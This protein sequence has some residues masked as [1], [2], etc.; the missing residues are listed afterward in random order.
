[1]SRE[2]RLRKDL[3]DVKKMKELNPSLFDFQVL[4][5]DPP[6]KYKFTF[7]VT[8]LRLVTGQSQPQR[9]VNH[10]FEVTLGSDYPAGGPQTQWL[11][12]IFHPNI[13]GAQVC[14]SKQW[15]ASVYLKHWVL[16]LYD[17]VRGVGYRSSSPLD[18]IAAKWYEANARVFPVDKRK[19][20]LP[21]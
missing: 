10:S 15:G 4:D 5:G 9:T 12:P 6:D 20:V 8:G 11:S 3:E 13:F 18:A 2:D 14:R 19:L 1:M 7:K 17:W 21:E 16:T